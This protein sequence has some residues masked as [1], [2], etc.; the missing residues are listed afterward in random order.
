MATTLTQR[1]RHVSRLL[2]VILG[3]A[4]LLTLF[5]PL[6]L[7]QAAAAEL[8]PYLDTALSAEERAADLV[9]RM[10]RNEKQTQLRAHAPAI[11]RLGLK[12]YMYQNEALHGMAKDGGTSFSSPI[13]MASSWNLDLMKGIGD[14]VGDEIRAYYNTRNNE[15]LSYWSPTINIHRDPRWGRNEESYSE[16]PFLTAA[17]GEMFVR[18]M[19]EGKTPQANPN[20]EGEFYIKSIPTLKHY[21]ANNSEGNRF[22]GSSNI[23]N[24]LMRDYYTWAF[25][26][27]TERTNVAS[28]MTAYNAVNG[29]PAAANDYL[30]NTLLRK[31][32]GFTGY[33]VGDCGALTNLVE[34]QHYVNNWAEAVALGLIGGTDQDCGGGSQNWIYDKYSLAAIDQG[35]MS[36]D[37]MDR[38][39]VRTLALR[40]RTGEFDGGAYTEYKTTETDA[41]RD[42]ALLVAQQSAILLENRNNALPIVLSGTGAASNINVYGPLARRTDLG[43]YSGNPTKDMLNFKTG[44]TNFIN[45][46][47]A[48]S[49]PPL[50]FYDG[51]TPSEVSDTGNML[52]V[53]WI[54]FG[55]GQI[56]HASRDA[57]D[58]FGMNYEGG[59][60]P[61]TSN[62]LYQ[63]SDGGWAKYEGV[64]LSETNKEFR[65]GGSSPRNYSTQAIF[66]LDSP[67]GIILGVVTIP[68]TNDWHSYSSTPPGSYAAITASTWRTAGFST[69]APALGNV[70]AGTMTINYD[71]ATAGSYFATDILDQ[72][73]ANGNIRDIYVEFIYRRDNQIQNDVI[74]NAETGKNADSVSVVYV[75]TTSGFNGNYSDIKTPGYDPAENN[76]NKWGAFK[77]G[78]EH[79]DRKSIKL[80][81]NQEELIDKVVTETRKHN[82]KVVVVIQSMG[83][84]DV[85]AFK[86]KVDAILWTPY[87]G[88]RQA[89]ALSTLLV[90]DYNPGGHTTQTWYKDDSQLTDSK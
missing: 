62:N 76:S 33:I 89:E 32:F 53:R 26:K 37:D 27:I 52:N 58:S 3:A 79:A 1:G 74:A 13:G 82:G 47:P 10:T 44:F 64:N 45:A 80:P 8:P 39:L 68:P 19:Q 83:C 81:A 61:A 16:D 46:K 35:F 57:K 25:Q 63:I 11:P 15:G 23:N 87:N 9:S 65:V 28:F 72:Q 69:A 86:D 40:F 17:M 54:G 6:T 14:V 4:M 12:Q 56:R 66:H 70:T 29:V 5:T 48:G 24:K 71:A 21:A 73:M 2:T 36:E 31:V 50:S 18:G 41:I 85:S 78:S 38:A 90:G 43:E 84:M 20:R 60:S 49:R 75:G 55:P 88:Q 51:M 7:F 77:V 34:K 42:Q 30:N 59:S 22:T 67:E